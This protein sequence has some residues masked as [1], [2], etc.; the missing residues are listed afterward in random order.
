MLCHPIHV[1]FMNKK[2]KY[3]LDFCDAIYKAENLA[4]AE[5]KKEIFGDA[6][7]PE[8]LLNKNEK[9]RVEIRSENVNHHAPHIHVKHSDRFDVSISLQDFSI[10]AG[11]IDK[12]TYKHLL[13]VLVP[14]K[15]TL[16]KIWKE[17]NENENS[18]GA[19]KIISSLGL[20]LG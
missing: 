16:L 14:N 6:F 15:E 7:V 13:C 17:L 4:Q 11:N 5:R 8:L 20:S 3:L 12:K 2:E 9:V 18:I 10:L 19:E 1:S